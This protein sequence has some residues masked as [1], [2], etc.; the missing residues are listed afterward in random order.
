VDGER[1]DDE[2]LWWSTTDVRNHVQAEMECFTN[3]AGPIREILVPNENNKRVCRRSLINCTPEQGD[4]DILHA[5]LAAIQRKLAFVQV[6]PIDWK[7]YVLVF[8]WGICLFESYLLYVPS[9]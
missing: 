4:M 1:D 5:Q 2:R 6:D 8:S 3:F 7:N 9:L